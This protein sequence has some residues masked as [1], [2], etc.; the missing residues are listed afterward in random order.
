MTKLTL[1]KKIEILNKKASFEYHF[2]DK[3]EAGIVLQG[4]EIKSIRLGNVNMGDAF[5]I[6]HNNEFFIKN[7][8]IGKY[9]KGTIYNHDPIRDRKLL[10]KKN[11]LRKIEKSLKEQGITVIPVKL[12]VNDKGLAKLEIAVAKG[13]KSHDKREDIKERETNREIRRAVSF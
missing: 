3:Y 9:E 1:N 8:H 12:F 6:F 13:K 4:T 10:L 7:L 11:E 2:M 5:C